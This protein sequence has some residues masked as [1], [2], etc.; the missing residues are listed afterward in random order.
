MQLLENDLRK[1]NAKLLLYSQLY[2]QAIQN[3][4][5][6]IAN[7]SAK[8]DKVGAVFQADLI[9]P[10][11]LDGRAKE[12]T[13]FNLALSDLFANSS[14]PIKLITYYETLSDYV[15]KY[16]NAEQTFLKNMYLFRDYFESKSNLGTLYSYYFTLSQENEGASTTVV[17]FSTPER[18]AKLTSSNQYNTIYEKQDEVYILYDKNEIIN[19]D[20]Y[21]NN[22]IYYLD[23]LSDNKKEINNNT[24]EYLG[25]NDE[26]VYYEL[27]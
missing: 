3:K 2:Y 1:A 23:P 10:F 25:Y 27:Q 5:K 21:N 19:K 22:N 7:L 12:T 14:E 24:P 26:Q 9:N 16:F 17:T 15:N 18:Y 20:N 13:E 11:M 6:I 8:I 4:T